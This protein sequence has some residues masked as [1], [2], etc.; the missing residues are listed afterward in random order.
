MMSRRQL[1]IS[2]FLITRDEA[3]RIGQTLAAIVDLVEEIIVVDSGSRDATIDI[4]RQYGAEVVHND[5]PGYG[6]QKRYAETLCHQDWLL[7]IDADEVV[8]PALA[9]EL[10]DLFANG[11]PDHKAYEIPIAETFPIETEPHRFAYTIAPVR[12]YRKDA[13]RYADSPVH[14]RVDLAPGIIPSRLYNRINHLTVRSLGDEVRKLNDYSDMQVDDMELRGRTV[15][16]VRILTEFPLAFFKAYFCAAIAC[17]GFTVWRRR[18]IMPFP[19]PAHCQGIGKKHHARPN[20]PQKN[21][22]MSRCQIWDISHQIDFP[23]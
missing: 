10:R 11:E 1:P 5:W 7:N 14:D 19:S 20:G 9:D 3:D 4:A 12:L 23:T 2:A 13:G 18:S 22:Q 17:A 21:R 6:P 8:P 16:P 15:S